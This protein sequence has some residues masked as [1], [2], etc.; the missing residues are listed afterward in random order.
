[1]KKLLS[2]FVALAVLL[3]ISSQ[4][5]FAEVLSQSATS[6]TTQD[7][8]SVTPTTQTNGQGAVQQWTTGN[9][10][11]SFKN[12]QT[13]CEAKGFYYDTTAKDCF[14]NNMGPQNT[15]S[16]TSTT[17]TNGQGTA[18]NFAQTV[19]KEVSK[20]DNFGQYLNASQKRT[21]F[22]KVLN[23]LQEKRNNF[24]QF[25]NADERRAAYETLKTELLAKISTMKETRKKAL[26]TKFESKT[27]K[28]IEK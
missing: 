12:D 22:N 9:D 25:L 6:G 5:V 2:S 14:P 21:T 17:Q 18:W 24:G 20:P 16:A 15:T 10:P 23:E 4:A 7:T 26:L 27:K 1:M 28:K 8:T 13:G 3:G 11:L 19:K